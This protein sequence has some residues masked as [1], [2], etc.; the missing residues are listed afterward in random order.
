MP[1]RMRR[2]SEQRS[3]TRNNMAKPGSPGWQ[4]ER[5][6]GSHDR[7]AFSCGNS[8]L[9]NFVQKLA[10]QY[11]RKGFAV[12][13]V[14]VSPP[15]KTVR[16]Y[17]SLSVSALA[18]ESLPEEVRRKL[19][20]H[21]LPTVLLARLAVDQHSQGQRLGETL[22]FDAFRR[23]LQI[24]QA[25]GIHAVEVQALDQQARRFYQKYG[26]VPLIDNPLHL[27]LPMRT[28]EKLFSPI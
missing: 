9:D 7:S 10:S 21:P 14:A 6:D 27:Y 1:N 11:E 28:V 12:T 8:V 18:G 2:S 16:G 4:I 3:A 15:H 13:Y 24:A 17:Y 19:P 5:L 26:F 20:R 23:C 25:L 22:L